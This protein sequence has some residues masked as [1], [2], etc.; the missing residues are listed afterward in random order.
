MADANV[1][2]T[3]IL[4]EGTSKR[5]DVRAKLSRGR[6]HFMTQELAS[7][8]D[9]MKISSQDAVILLGAVAR[10]FNVNLEELT[11]NRES[12]QKERRVFR[13]QR[14]V[15]FKKNFK[16]PASPFHC[17]IY[18]SGVIFSCYCIYVH[19]CIK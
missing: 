2:E 18:P 10:A 1:N 7:T 4:N 9:K 6:K 19:T 11:L 16:F 17:I 14:A 8:L 3:G 5:T 15:N 12:I 13:E